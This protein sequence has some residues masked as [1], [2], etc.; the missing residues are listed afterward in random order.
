MLP[1]TVTRCVPEPTRLQVLGKALR[2]LRLALVWGLLVLLA[3]RIK[4]ESFTFTTVVG[5]AGSFGTADGTNATVRLQHPKGIVLDSATNLYMADGD[6][7]RKL[8]QVGT[9]WVVTT[10]AGIA[11]LH[12]TS[13]G[14][15]SDA[16]FNDPGSVA[17][18]AAGV[19]FV[20]DNKNNAIRKVTP[21]GTN[22]VVTTI[23]GVADPF[24]SGTNDGVGSAARF[25][26]PQG[27]AVDG[28]GNL[29]VADTEN[30]TIRK[31]S[32]VGTNWVVSTIAGSARTSGSNDG[33]NTNAR[34]N[35]PAGV[36]V[37]SATNLFV[38]DLL[39]H[40]IRKVAPSG[41]NW[42]VSTVAGLAGI[43]GSADGTNS[44]ARF[45][46]PQGVAV[47]AAGNLYV[48][49][50]LNDTIRKVRPA[51]TNWVVSTLAGLAGATGSTDGTGSAARFNNPN[52]VAVDGLGRLFVADSDNFTIRLGQLAILLQITRAANQVQ[53]SWPA[54]ATDFVLET[55]NR[56]P[57]IGPWTRLTNAGTI[58]GDNLVLTTNEN[59]PAAFFRL[60]KP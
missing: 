35:L 24:T 58:V 8:A 29:Y 50:S 56:L 9:N 7:I 26:S 60:H 38:A 19:L 16:L 57:A 49:D 2:A 41:A 12:G 25:N 52:G 40:T 43:S 42:V 46:L 20:A 37:D 55:T 13:D 21:A 44:A 32:P 10:V 53:V 31:L 1:L 3:Q 45:N 18:D 54:A 48:T 51:G 11:N 39:N 34:F 5:V 22:W 17:V 36:A 14:T 27:I 47:S 23:A 33:T 59:A 4:A 30:E 28:G 6:A 15:N